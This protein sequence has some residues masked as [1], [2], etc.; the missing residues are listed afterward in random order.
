MF[1]HNVIAGIYV[2]VCTYITKYNQLRAYNVTF[3]YV[4][5]AKLLTLDK[6]FDVFFS[7]EDRLSCSQI[8]SV[9]YIVLS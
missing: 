2:F 7:V 9:A 3:L 4:F 6:Q 8:Y 1:S 5:R